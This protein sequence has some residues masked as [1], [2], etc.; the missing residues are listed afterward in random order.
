MQV[1]HVQLVIHVQLLIRIDFQRP[2]PAWASAAAATSESSHGLRL[3]SLQ[4]SSSKSL[5]LPALVTVAVTVTQSVTAFNVLTS[6]LDSESDSD[7]GS[8]SRL[9]EGA[10]EVGP[11]QA[12][13][14]AGFT[15]RHIA[16]Q[17]RGHRCK[18]CAA[19]I[20]LCYPDI[21]TVGP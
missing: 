13:T 7:S 5:R 10:K 8:E 4:P 21:V 9:G 20:S 19:H 15:S 12:R 18:Q 14:I 2:P 11:P 3:V 17:R 1:V 16:R 6:D